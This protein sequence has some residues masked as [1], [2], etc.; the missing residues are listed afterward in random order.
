MPNLIS[1]YVLY[2]GATGVYYG[3]NAQ[4]T[5]FNVDRFAVFAPRAG[6]LKRKVAMGAGG[7]SIFD[8]IPTFDAN[9]PE[10]DAN[11]L[12]GVFIQQDEGLVMVDAEGD[13]AA[14]K[15]QT[16]L[17]VADACCDGDNTIPREYTSGVPAF[18]NPT[19]SNYTITREDD[20]TPG[21]IDQFSMDYMDQVVLDPIHVSWITGTSTYSINCFGTPTLVGEDVLV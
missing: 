2:N 15:V 16:V 5:A 8:Y 10:I 20:G 13:T 17:D 6:W 12:A 4:L 21:A 1:G 18:S 9:D 19:A 11:T 3:D 14:E 7:G